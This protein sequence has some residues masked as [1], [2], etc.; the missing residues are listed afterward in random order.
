MATESYFWDESF[1]AENDLSSKQYYA[2]E[3]SAADQVDACD[4]IAD[5]VIG[6]LQ[7]DPTTSHAAQVR[8]MGMTKWVSDGT[9]AGGIS[10]GSLVGTSATGK[11][12]AKATADYTVKGMAMD[13]SSADGTIIR[14]LLYPACVPWRTALDA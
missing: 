11:C 9:A 5:K 12:I 8:I 13:A 2:V 3:L 6:V 10:A 14:V 1:K 4:G 7:N